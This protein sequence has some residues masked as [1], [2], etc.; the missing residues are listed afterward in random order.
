M[1]RQRE[2]IVRNRRS[3]ALLAVFGALSFAVAAEHSGLSHSEDP[4]H[5]PG[6]IVISMCL[7]VLTVGAAVC[8][9]AAAALGAP[10]A[11][12]AR[13]LG[14]PS[15]VAAIEPPVEPPRTR[16][17]PAFLQSFRS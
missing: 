13:D 2:F 17:G 10:L 6:T 3:F 15:L 14:S 11:R 5:D 12:P 4:A 8:A 9:A 16:A 1:I 7:A